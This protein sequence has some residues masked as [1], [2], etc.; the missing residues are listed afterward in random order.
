[1]YDCI[2][3]LNEFFDGGKRAALNRVMTQLQGVRP[4]H[5]LR[6][7]GPGCYTGREPCVPMV[8]FPHAGHHPEETEGD[9]QSRASV[10]RTPGGRDA[11]GH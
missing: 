2:K 8:P 4:G 9:Q 6:R 5:G 11:G 7:Q 3:R 1:M 10:L